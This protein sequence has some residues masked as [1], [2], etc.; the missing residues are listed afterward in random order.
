MVQRDKS[1]KIA[2]LSGSR[3][4][5]R[6]YYRLKNNVTKINRVSKTAVKTI[7]YGMS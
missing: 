1:K 3:E 2:I 5:W 6:H 7:N 4:D